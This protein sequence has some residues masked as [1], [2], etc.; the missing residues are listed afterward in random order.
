MITSP[1]GSITAG[2]GAGVNKA[3][4]ETGEERERVV[5]EGKSEPTQ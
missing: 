2:R 4:A 5:G 3:N 1:P